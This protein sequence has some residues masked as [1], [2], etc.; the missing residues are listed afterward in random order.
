[1]ENKFSEW[2]NQTIFLKKYGDVSIK[3]LL[4]IFVNELIYFIQKNRYNIC[5]PKTVFGNTLASMLYKLDYD[6]HYIYHIPNN[7]KFDYL[8]E[9][10]ESNIDWET[11]W[12]I[13]N[14]NTNNFFEEAEIH[15]LHAVWAYIDFD[16]SDAQIEYLQSLEDSDS[17]DDTPKILKNMDPYLLDQLNVSN[18]YKFTRFDNS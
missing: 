14:Y 3:F 2:Q 7:I 16:K 9:Y 4:H 1:M 10:F 17:E 6:R 11:F 15:I 13:W 12:K 5:V 8:Y 18:H